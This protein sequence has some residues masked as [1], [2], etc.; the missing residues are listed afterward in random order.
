MI[1]ANDLVDLVNW[2]A[3][4]P[5]WAWWVFYLAMFLTGRELGRRF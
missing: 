3:M 2:M 1:G 4:W 5:S